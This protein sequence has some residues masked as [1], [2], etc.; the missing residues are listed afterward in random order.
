M[1][2]EAKIELYRQIHRVLRT[3]I[4]ELLNASRHARDSDREGAEFL[5]RVRQG[6]ID[7]TDEIISLVI[8]ATHEAYLDQ[9]IG[10]Y[11]PD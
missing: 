11:K 1:D 6:H 10:P 5:D 7:M 8:G 3:G 2:D 4:R 9:I